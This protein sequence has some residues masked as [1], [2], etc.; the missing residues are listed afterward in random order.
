[1]NRYKNTDIIDSKFSQTIFP[2]IEL[3]ENDL[4][5]YARDGDRL[6]NLAYKYYSDTTLWWIIARANDLVGDSMFISI[7][8]R[9]RIPMNISPILNAINEK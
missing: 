6:D 8:A 2:K 9:L 3:S 4:Y 5:I 7:P 1:M